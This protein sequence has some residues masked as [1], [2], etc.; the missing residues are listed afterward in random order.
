MSS[1]GYFILGTIISIPIAIAA[2]LGTAVIQKRLGI[3]SEKQDLRRLE[4]LEREYALVKDYRDNPTRL[5]TYVGSKIL[6][7]LLFYIGQEILP[8]AASFMVYGGD[9]LAPRASAAELMGVNVAALSTAVAALLGAIVL[10]LLFRTGF[11]AYRIVRKVMAFDQYESEV[12]SELS[13][14]R[15]RDKAARAEAQVQVT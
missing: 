6:I 3:R 9:L 11:R 13:A 4:A 1:F 15:A 14:I 7:L 5:L 12:M 10:G 2:P 8:A